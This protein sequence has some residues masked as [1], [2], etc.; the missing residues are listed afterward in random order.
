MH[1]TTQVLRLIS[2]RPGSTADDILPDCEGYSRKQV[3][4]SL[5]WLTSE[6]KLRCHEQGGLTAPGRGGSFPA[7][8]YPKNEKPRPANSVWQLAER[9]LI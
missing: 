3:M 5:H 2:D 8:Y 4:S 1:L 9:A 7:K 6:E